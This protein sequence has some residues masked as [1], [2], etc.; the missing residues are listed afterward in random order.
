MICFEATKVAKSGAVSR[1]QAI[2][3]LLENVMKSELHLLQQVNIVN[4][5]RT[6]LVNC[7]NAR[8]RGLTFRHRASCI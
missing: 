7:L 1:Y 6:G 2:A 4:T 3:G 5:L 8:S